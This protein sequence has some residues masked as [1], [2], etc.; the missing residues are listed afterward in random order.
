MAIPE[1]VQQFFIRDLGWIKVNLNRFSVIA[2]IVIGGVLL[3]SPC[4]PNTGTNDTRDT[5]EPGVRSP[6]SAKRKCCH[7][8]FKSR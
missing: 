3:R 1:R 6:E 4:I 2:Q 5:P 8:C 7:F